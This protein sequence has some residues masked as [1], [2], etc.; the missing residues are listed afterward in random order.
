MA[1]FSTRV[2]SY[3][4]LS[5]RLHVVGGGGHGGELIVVGAG[6]FLHLDA[7]GVQLEGGHGGDPALRRDVVE[8]VHVNLD[9]D[10]VTNPYPE[11]SHPWT[12]TSA[13]APVPAPVPAK[14]KN[15]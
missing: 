14:Q 8:V 7:V 2:A 1:S 11:A 10:H 4:L 15:K 12:P 9:K 13:P 6:H 5:R 3:S